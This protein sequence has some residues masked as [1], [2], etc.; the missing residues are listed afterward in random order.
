MALIMLGVAPPTR[1]VTPRWLLRAFGCCGS[2]P[3]SSCAICLL[4]CGL[5]FEN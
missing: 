2:L 5:S 1:G 4:R 3:R